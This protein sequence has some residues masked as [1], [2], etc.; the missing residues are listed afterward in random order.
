[1]INKKVAKRSMSPR[2]GVQ[3]SNLA[4]ER[5]RAEGILSGKLKVSAT[6]DPELAM[7]INTIVERY[8]I[9]ELSM[10]VALK[11]IQVARRLHMLSKKAKRIK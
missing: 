1:V 9:G 7:R 5:R 4:V 6:K 11:K 10:G 3:D 2:L 8:K